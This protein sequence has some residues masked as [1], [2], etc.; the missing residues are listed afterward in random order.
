LP[1]WQIGFYP[2]LRVFCFS[3]L[4]VDLRFMDTI[5][6]GF[7]KTHRGAFPGFSPII[8]LYQKWMPPLFFYNKKGH[9]ANVHAF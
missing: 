4:T 9:P 7:F 5:A 2:W 6:K 3:Y 8:F 1:S